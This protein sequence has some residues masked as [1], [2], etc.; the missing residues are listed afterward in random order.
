MKVWT[1]TLRL[2]RNKKKNISRLMIFPYTNTFTQI[3]C[4]IFNGGAGG[5]VKGSWNTKINYF[6]CYTVGN[7]VR[8][9]EVTLS[10]SRVC[11]ASTTVHK[12]LYS[13]NIQQNSKCS[14]SEEWNIKVWYLDINSPQENLQIISKP[15]SEL[16]STR[17]DQIL[18]AS[19]RF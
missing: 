16:K 8:S 2:I 18:R 4:I 1:Q 13:G 5:T 17:A 7:S 10:M 15:S 11:D 19:K 14:E 3:V 6:H 9:N 12:F